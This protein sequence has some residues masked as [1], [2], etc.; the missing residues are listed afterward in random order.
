MSDMQTVASYPSRF[1]GTVTVQ[2]F[3]GLDGQWIID[4]A[5]DEEG[6]PFAVPEFEMDLAIEQLS[7]AALQEAVDAANERAWLTDRACELHGMSDED[8][9]AFAFAFEAELELAARAGAR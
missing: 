9:D 3:I 4:R 2:G 8:L 5:T 1:G 7:D 6:C